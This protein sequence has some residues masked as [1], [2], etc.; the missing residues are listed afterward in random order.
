[1]VKRRVLT[2]RSLPGFSCSK[3]LVKELLRLDAH[4]GCG[5]CGPVFGASEPHHD[6]VNS[7]LAF[8]QTDGRLKTLIRED[9][10]Y[11]YGSVRISKRRLHSRLQHSRLLR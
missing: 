8:V 7:R 11:S 2:S 4:G 9:F 1:V 10:N 5:E 6:R 3:R